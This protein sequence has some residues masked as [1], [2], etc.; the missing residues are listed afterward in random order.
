M[1]TTASG[2]QFRIYHGLVEVRGQVTR[3]WLGTITAGTLPAEARP[4]YQAAI[5]TAAGTV[6]AVYAVV[7]TSG[8]IDIVCAAGFDGQVI[9]GGTFDLG[10]VL[11]EPVNPI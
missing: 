10:F 1:G 5:S 11:P 3:N 9:L 8:A 6:A 2:F 7:R 4:R